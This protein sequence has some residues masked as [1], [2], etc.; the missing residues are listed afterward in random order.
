M[1]YMLMIVLTLV[2][3]IWMVVRIWSAAGAIWGLG[4]LFIPVVSVVYV[5]IHWSDEDGVKFP[6]FAGILTSVIAVTVQPTLADFVDPEMAAAMLEDP[7]IQRQMAEDPEFRAEME[8]LTGE[9]TASTESED[10]DTSDSDFVDDGVS[11]SEQG[12]SAPAPKTPSTFRSVPSYS[13]TEQQAWKLAMGNLPRRRGTVALAGNDASIELPERMGF[14]DRQPLA[15]ALASSKE[16]LDDDVIGW[17]VHDDAPIDD[18]FNAW[19]IEV[20]S[21]DK[22]HVPLGDV[23]SADQLDRWKERAF[24]IASEEGK[25]SGKLLSFLGFPVAPWVDEEAAQVAWVA[26]YGAGGDQAHLCTGLALGR[27]RQVAYTMRVKYDDRWQELCLLS[28]RTLARK[29]TFDAGQ[30]YPDY[31]RFVDD[32]SNVDAVDYVVGAERIG[33]GL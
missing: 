23:A 10:L 24:S 11:D 32:R 8:A 17:V 14:V 16:S 6:F 12:V 9:A 25:A 5:I 13:A 3:H 31:T 1:L 33:K 29:T 21:L 15:L 27:E 26:S 19:W 20:R 4:S 2:F 28:V 7:E 30:G 22:G 18:R